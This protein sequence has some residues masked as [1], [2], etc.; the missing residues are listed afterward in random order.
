MIESAKVPRIRR[1]NHTPVKTASVGEN[2][3]L[4]CE[5]SKDV[6]NRRFYQ[7]TWTK[8]GTV[9]TK[10]SRYKIRRFTFLKIRSVTVKDSGIYKCVVRNKN[11]SDSITTE[12]H[13]YCK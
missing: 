4:F 2:V 10:N 1:V 3:K 8:D 5:I 7:Y 11:G 13:I 12:V 9:L 6:E